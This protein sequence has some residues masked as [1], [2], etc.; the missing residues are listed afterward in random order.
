MC[1][2][3]FTPSPLHPFTRAPIRPRGGCHHEP[4]AR[5]IFLRESTSNASSVYTVVV[6]GA[7]MGIFVVA[8][9]QHAAD[10]HR[11]LVLPPLG[12][13]RARAL[14][15]SR[16]TAASPAASTA[17]A[18]SS[19][20]L[21]IGSAPRT[22]VA[23]PVQARE[24]RCFRVRAPVCGRIEVRLILW[25]AVGRV[26]VDVQ[27]GPALR[28][29]DGASRVPHSNASSTFSSVSASTSVANI[30][31]VS[32]KYRLVGTRT[33]PSSR[34]APRAATASPPP[35]PVL[36]HIL[37]RRERRA[38]ACAPGGWPPLSSSLSSSI[39]AR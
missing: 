5:T 39:P 1:C 34:R 28:W 23:L 11:N 9:E 15:A 21:M 31:G 3:P 2:D 26:R 36:A 19:R 24:C 32:A 6:H 25:P 14:A 33:R 12:L 18:S 29:S 38:M 30:T 4:R 13:V 22:G 20:L 27:Y 10:V 7:A 35:E 17:S 16:S 8:V 37:L